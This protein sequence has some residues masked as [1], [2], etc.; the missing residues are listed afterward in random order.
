M[1]YDVIKLII[2][3]HIPGSVFV[4]IGHRISSSPLV[5]VGLPSPEDFQEHCRDVGVN[6]DTHL[7]LYDYTAVVYPH[8][9]PRAW[10]MF[11]VSC[12]KANF[13]NIKSVIALLTAFWA[14]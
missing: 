5:P 13:K 12:E 3:I 8:S 4:D 11:R 6:E 1:N 9:T 7:V 14:R 2:S 10:W